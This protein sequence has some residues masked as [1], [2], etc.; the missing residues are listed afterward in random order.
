LKRGSSHG[1]YYGPAHSAPKEED[2]D[3]KWG[4]RRRNSDS[5]VKRSPTGIV[6]L[7]LF[8]SLTAHWRNRGSGFTICRK[9]TKAAIFRG[10]VRVPLPRATCSA[11][12]VVP[13]RAPMEFKP[14]F[15]V[16]TRFIQPPTN[17]L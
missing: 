8:P 16:A 3:E 14:T 7:Q 10:F 2:L 15:A 17:D 6:T 5:R 12:Q 9:D 11:E 4:S 1:F 13:Q